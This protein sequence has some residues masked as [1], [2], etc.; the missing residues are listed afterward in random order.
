MNDSSKRFQ[1]NWKIFQLHL[2]P[3]LAWFRIFGWGLFAKDTRSHPLLFSQR[4]SLTGQ[5][6]G[7]YF[8]EILKP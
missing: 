5:K 1:I 4:N 2:E 6:V 3:G 8:F 7:D